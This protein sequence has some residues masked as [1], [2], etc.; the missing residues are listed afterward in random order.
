MQILYLQN[1]KHLH[2]NTTT[3]NNNDDLSHQKTQNNNINNAND[4]FTI[5]K[6]VQLLICRLEDDSLDNIDEA[7]WSKLFYLLGSKVLFPRIFKQGSQLS[8]IY[9]DVGQL[10]DISPDRD[11]IHYDPIIVSFLE[12]LSKRGFSFQNTKTKYYLIC[13]IESI[14]SFCNFNW[15]L[16]FNFVSNLNQS[17]ISGSKMVTVLNGKLSPGG[18]YTTNLGEKKNTNYALF[19]LVNQSFLTLIV[20]KIWYKYWIP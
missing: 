4:K 14:Y 8:K 16:P 15:V 3:Y 19:L 10:I 6:L 18:G 12:G 9:K 2:Q 17:F 20:M 11:I 13:I 5:Q 7:D 1:K